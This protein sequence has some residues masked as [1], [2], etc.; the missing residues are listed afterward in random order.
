MSLLDAVRTLFSS[1]DAKLQR[2]IA[3]AAVPDASILDKMDRKAAIVDAL[4][5]IFPGSSDEIWVVVVFNPFSPTEYGADYMPF[6]VVA[7]FDELPEAEEFVAGL[8]PLLREDNGCDIFFTGELEAKSAGEEEWE[9]KS[10]VEYY[11]LVPWGATMEELV[12]IMA[13]GVLEYMKDALSHH[14]LPSRDMME[15][16]LDSWFE[17]DA[18]GDD[19]F[20]H[21]VSE[22]DADTFFDQVLTRAMKL[23]EEL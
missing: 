10:D 11:G 18:N 9:P 3:C 8:D 6:F 13:D 2:E 21:L 12:S 22:E 4:P 15:S 16:V 20:D 5:K 19:R 7:E 23:A 17:H 14:V 1:D